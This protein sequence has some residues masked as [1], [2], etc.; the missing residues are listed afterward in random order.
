MFSRQR[1]SAREVAAWSKTMLRRALGHVLLYCIDNIGTT[2]VLTATGTA[3]VSYGLY[4][5]YAPAAYIVAG[6]IVLWTALPQR[7]MF[8]YRPPAA[9][10]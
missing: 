6:A 8:V 9:K 2:E 7:P 5:V 4:Q 1:R 3:L 10:R